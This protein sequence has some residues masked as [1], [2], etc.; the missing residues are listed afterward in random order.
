MK[1]IAALHLT[2]HKEWQRAAYTHGADGRDR[3]VGEEGGILLRLVCRSC[4]AQPGLGIG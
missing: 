2:N 3:S 4:V 1:S